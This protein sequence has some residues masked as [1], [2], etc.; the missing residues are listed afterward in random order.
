[1]LRANFDNADEALFPSQFVNVVMLL[2]TLKDV[3]RYRLRAVQRGAPG[4][5]VYLVGDRTRYRSIRSSS[6]AQDG[7]FFAV[8]RGLVAR[9]C[10]GHRRRRPPARRCQSEHS[11]PRPRRRATAAA[12]ERPARAPTSATARTRAIGAGGHG[13]GQ[14]HHRHAA[15]GGSSRPSRQPSPRSAAGPRRRSPLARM[16]PSRLFINLPVATSL[17]MVAI[18]LS[19]PVRVQIPAA[20]LAAGGRLSDHPGADLLSG[21]EPGGHDLLGHGAARAAVRPDARSQSDDLGELGRRVRHHAAVQPRSRPRCGGAGGAGGDQCGGQR[22]CRTIC[23]RRR[24]TPS[25]TRPTRPS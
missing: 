20:V 15:A 10:G 21:R 23:R 17:L 3:V 9:R 8:D 19:R 14:H 1:M 16:N 4:T 11:E 6:G 25:S 24:P 13:N 2:D 22:A 12:A 5:Y 18:L 7:D